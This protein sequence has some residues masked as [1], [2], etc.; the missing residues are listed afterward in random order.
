[1]WRRSATV[2]LRSTVLGPF[3]WKCLRK[4]CASMRPV[5]AF[6]SSLGMNSYC[7]AN[8][9]ELEEWHTSL[10]WPFG[11][12]S[13]TVIM[14]AKSVDFTKCCSNEHYVGQNSAP[15]SRKLTKGVRIS[16]S[17]SPNLFKKYLT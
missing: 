9:S 11:C 2:D 7:M 16:T 17:S 15:L 14:V 1:M 10:T 8:I 12:K 5:Y 6:F 13:S 4:T 3:A